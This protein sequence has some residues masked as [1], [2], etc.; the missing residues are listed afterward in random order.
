MQ[1]NKKHSFVR[2]SPLAYVVVPLVFTVISAVI[3]F[4]TTKI[5][6]APYQAL[7]S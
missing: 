2:R 6:L 1:S 3:F 5:L 4:T 7:I